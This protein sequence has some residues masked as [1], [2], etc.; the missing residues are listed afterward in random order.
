MQGFDQ[1]CLHIGGLD[2]GITTDIL[3]GF[4]KKYNIINIHLPYDHSR[5][6]PKNYAFLYFKDQQMTELAYKECNF[7]KILK[8]PINLS[9]IINRN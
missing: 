6:E 8:K 3:Y 1:N 4:F 5:K 7:K 9:A 2:R